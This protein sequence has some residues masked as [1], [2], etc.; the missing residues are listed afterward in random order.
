VEDDVG[1]DAVEVHIASAH[2]RIVAPFDAVHLVG[3]RSH[4]RSDFVP[5]GTLGHLT[6]THAEGA[7]FF[8][9]IHLILKRLAVCGGRIIRVHLDGRANVRVCGYDYIAAKRIAS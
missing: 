7:L 1:S 5:E 8:D 9:H 2:L 4:F 3:R 6:K